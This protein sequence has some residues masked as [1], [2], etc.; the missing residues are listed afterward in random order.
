M[1]DP[2]AKVLVKHIG[3]HAKR[4][5]TMSGEGTVWHGEG[6]V[7]P[8]SRGAWEKHLSRHPDLWVLVGDAPTAAP[9]P[10]LGLAQPPA[11]SEPPA[12]A[13]AEPPA[14]APADPPAPPAP[15]PAPAAAKAVAKPKR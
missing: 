11:P 12:P 4:A 8:V 9:A 6:D 7:Q 2:T 14:P 10:G 3:K 5:D 15:A 13:P 1:N